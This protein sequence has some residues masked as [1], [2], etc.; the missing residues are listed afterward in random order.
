M[1]GSPSLP[2]SSGST[3]IEQ[4][5]ASHS[6]VWGAGEDTRLSP[7][8]PSIVQARAAAG[9]VTC[10]SWLAALSA[11]VVTCRARALTGLLP[12]TRGGLSYWVA[13]GCPVP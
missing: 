12:T 9:A 11:H 7:L 3:L 8:I 6:G 10:T 5:L 13:A 4:I 2:R 1:P